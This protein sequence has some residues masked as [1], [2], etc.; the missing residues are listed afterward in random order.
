MVDIISFS[1]LPFYSFDYFV[2]VRNDLRAEFPEALGE[3][4]KTDSPSEKE[5]AVLPEPIPRDLI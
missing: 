5:N 4:V 3:S 2:K 1:Q